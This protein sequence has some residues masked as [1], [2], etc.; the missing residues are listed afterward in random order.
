MDTKGLLSNEMKNNFIKGVWD[1]HMK[2]GISNFTKPDFLH[3]QHR[4]LM[5]VMKV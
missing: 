4:C 1:E 2:Y 5:K 3:L